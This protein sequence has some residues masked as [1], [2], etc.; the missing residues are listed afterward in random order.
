MHLCQR[1][2]QSSKHFWNALLGIALSSS[3]DAAL[4]SSIVANLRPFMGLFNFGK[5]KKSQGAKSGEYGGWGMM[6]VLFLAKKLLTSNDVL[7]RSF[8]TNFADT[9]V[10]PKTSVK[11]DWHEP[12]DML[13][14][15]AISLIVIRRFFNT[16]SFTSWTFSSVFDV[17]GRPERGSSLTFSRPS[18][19]NLYHL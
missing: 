11:I 7:E 13:R 6:I 12:N 17:L 4:I 15:S 1:F 9:R 19:N 16:I 18:W 8:G 10:I 3:S 2:F 14:S 5:R